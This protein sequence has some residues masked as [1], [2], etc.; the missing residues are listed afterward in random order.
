MKTQRWLSI[1][2]C[3]GLVISLAGIGLAQQSKPTDPS[4]APAPSPPGPQAQKEKKPDLVVDSISITKTGEVAGKHKV[5]VNVTIKNLGGPTAG[6]LTAD[7][8][9]RAC[10]GA[11][12]ALVEWTVDPTRGFTRLCESGI[13]ALAAGASQTFFCDDEVP[14]QGFKKYRVTADYLNWIDESDEGNNINSAGYTAR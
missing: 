7:G 9:A 14:I 5:K 12:K 2:L 3:L 1:L 4:K 11:S 6:S 10:G 13:G 8:R